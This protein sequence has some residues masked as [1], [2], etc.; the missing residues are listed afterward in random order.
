M[1]TAGFADRFGRPR[2]AVPG[3]ISSPLSVGPNNLLADRAHV[4]R[5]AQ[6][7]L[8]VLRGDG[9]AAANRV[10]DSPPEGV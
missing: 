2:G 6:D 10:A 9:R 8:D 1:I 3:P 5:S 4:I 7:V